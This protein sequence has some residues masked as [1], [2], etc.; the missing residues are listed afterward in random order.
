MVEPALD[1]ETGLREALQY[2][3]SG[4]LAEAERVYKSILEVDPGHSDALHLLGVIAL[5]AG[6]YDIAEDL[7]DRAICRNPNSPAYHNNLGIALKNQQKIAAAIASYQKALQL[8][9]DYAKAYV[10]LGDAYRTEGNTGQAVSCYRKSLDLEPAHEPY[11]NLGV[12][13]AEQGDVNEAIHCYRRALEL[14]PECPEAYSNL[15]DALQLQTRLTDAICCYQT[16]LELD[17]ASAEAYNNMGNALKDQ[18]KIGEAISCYQQALML[19]PAYT[20]AHSN[21]LLSLHYQSAVDPVEL[22]AQHKAWDGR[23][24]SHVAGAI[25]YHANDRTPDRR[26]R[27]G[28]VSP[29]FRAHSVASFIEPVIASHDS[30]GFD[31][32]CYSDVARPDSVTH[33][34]KEL[35]GH[36]RDIRS[37]PDAGAADLIRRDGIDI[38]VELAGHTAGNRLRMLARKPAPVQATYLGYPDTTGLAAIDYRITD[39]H[40]DPPGRTDP[41]HTE[42]LTR[43]PRGFLCYRPSQGVLGGSSSPLRQEPGTITFGS[44]NHS[45]K[46]NAEVAR[47]WSRILSSLPAAR[48]VL[49]SRSFSDNAAVERL[50]DLFQQN[51]VDPHRIGFIS[52]IPSHAEH[53]G[54]YKSMDV[55]LDTFP[56]NG[57]TTTCEAMWMGVP[58]IS[59]AGETHASRVGVSL[60]S[61]VGLPELIADSHEDYVKKALALARDPQRLQDLRAIL[62]PLM[63]NSSLMDESGFTRS[64]E[65]AYRQMWHR[66]CTGFVV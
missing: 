59:L 18:G 4:L 60:L 55:A 27:I 49:K 48:L 56:Y 61:S 13:F 5:R 57:T 11:N 31:V 23:H 25:A 54:L 2:Q 3:Q 17:P 37:M 46:T 53:L 36:W 58:V 62:R 50:R 66:W 42:E 44:F 43:L 12:L 38:L 20:E 24:A 34:I 1:I 63:T 21:L 52:Y 29:D 45:P 10:G 40:A 14:R 65:E 28:Y 30:S 19:R 7:I 22:F 47:L 51:G 9:P 15:G 39:S 32:Y 35:A 41:F 16:A 64:L 6:K 8:H 33:R 26:L